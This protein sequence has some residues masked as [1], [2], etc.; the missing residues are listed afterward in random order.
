MPDIPSTLATCPTNHTSTLPDSRAGVLVASGDRVVDVDQDTR[1]SSLVSTGERDGRTRS[2]RTATSDSDLRARDVELGSASGGGSVD[3]DILGTEEVV[4][5]RKRLGN[6]ESE[7]V[8]V[9]G[10]EADLAV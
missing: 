6:G 8:A 10:W 4:T 2:S 9:L 1:V 5:G 7:G 3:G